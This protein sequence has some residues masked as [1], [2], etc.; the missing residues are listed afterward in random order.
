MYVENFL[1]EED[2]HTQTGRPLELLVL[3]KLALIRVREEGQAR[4]VI[5][6]V[7]ILAAIVL[8]V[9]ISLCSVDSGV[10]VGH[11]LGLSADLV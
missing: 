5:V 10:N 4:L 11:G 3:I 2:S 8:R 6:F 7:V 9:N 1:A